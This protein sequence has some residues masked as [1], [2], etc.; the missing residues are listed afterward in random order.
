MITA[1][2]S[3]YCLL[4]QHRVGI[5]TVDTITLIFIKREISIKAWEKI[6]KHESCQP[7]GQHLSPPNTGASMPRDFQKPSLLTLLLQFLMPYLPQWLCPL[8]SWR[9]DLSL[10]YAHALRYLATSTASLSL[11]SDQ[12]SASL[13]SLVQYQNGP[14][15]KFS[16]KEITHWL[17]SFVSHL[18][19]FRGRNTYLL[20]K[21]FI[22]VSVH[23]LM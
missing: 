21:H 12:L 2:L 20:F 1:N 9:S 8:S 22:L 5:T 23:L 6:S 14:S 19:W 11:A 18:C 4:H 10:A 7:K 13:L 3:I 17:F 16:S 15:G